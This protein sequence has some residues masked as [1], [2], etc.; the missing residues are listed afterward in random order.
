M[1]TIGYEKFVAPDD[2]V[3]RVE[4]QLDK[5]YYA[6]PQ[7]RNIVEHSLESYPS[8]R[9]A[10][11]LAITAFCGEYETER[12]TVCVRDARPPWQVAGC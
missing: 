12:R 2:V 7:D 10:G 4:G 3:K 6:M 11:V 1:S 8:N 9:S 5:I